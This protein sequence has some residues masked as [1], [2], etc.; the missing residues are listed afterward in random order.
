MSSSI[1]ILDS[2]LG[3]LSVASEINKLMPK[4]QIV[5]LGDSKNIPYSVKSKEEILKLSKRI[6]K[7]LLK[8]NAKII[9]IACNT[10]TVVALDKLR[11][12]F[13]NVPIIGT[14]PVIKTAVRITKNGKIGVFST[15]KT[16][17][18]KYQKDLIKIFAKNI[19]VVNLG[20]DEVVP[21]IEKGE[22]EILKSVLSKEL[23]PFKEFGVDIL[24][25]GCTHFP[26]IKEE[27]QNIVGS[28]VLVIDSGPAVARQVKRVL[29]QRQVLSKSSN[30]NVFYTT[31]DVF[32]MQKIVKKLG[33]SGKVESMD[34]K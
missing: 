25:L 19:S 23:A 15:K 31:G 9:V 2:G 29:E 34:L 21:L 1:G 33:F 14:V 32:Q 4:E 18:S 7:F 8:K 11:E 20:S 27:I 30:G 10:I 6:I 12:E 16:A 13:P 24:A 28:D 26:L 22:D 5:Y 3:G 17:E